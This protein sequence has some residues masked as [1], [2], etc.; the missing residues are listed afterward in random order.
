MVKNVIPNRNEV[1]SALQKGL[2]K[3]GI[4]LTG[5]LHSF[6]INL[7]NSFK[8]YLGS[9]EYKAGHLKSFVRIAVR[10]LLIDDGLP[11]QITDCSVASQVA[12]G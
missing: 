4:L 8:R 1:L 3:E 2:A 10:E 9:R 6:K 12:T 11:R 5:E 7:H